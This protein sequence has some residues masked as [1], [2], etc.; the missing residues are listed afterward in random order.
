MAFKLHLLSYEAVCM[1]KINLQ[2]LSLSGNLK[3]PSLK[4]EGDNIL[5]A[6]FSIPINEKN[7]TEI[8]EFI[9]PTKLFD[10]F[11]NNNFD[12]FKNN[13][14]ENPSK[15]LNKQNPEFLN[16]ENEFI[17]KNGINSNNFSEG[18]TKGNLN[19][20]FKENKSF[21]TIFFKSKK[22]NNVT[23]KIDISDYLKSKKNFGEKVLKNNQ[24][25][26]EDLNKVKIQFN[27][28][29]TYP[30]KNILKNQKITVSNSK[31]IL[32]DVKKIDINLD[33]NSDSVPLIEEKKG[34]VEMKPLRFNNNNELSNLKLNNENMSFTSNSVNKAGNLNFDKN[35]SNGQNNFTNDRNMN[36]VLDNFIEQLDLSEKGWT[37]KLV[38][39][40]EKA[41]LDGTEEIELF[42]KP[43]E[44]G[45]LKINLSV[46]KNNAKI[47]FKAENIFTI[48]SLQ[49]NEVLLT[50]FFNEQGINIEKTNYENSNFL[51]NNSENF[52][53]NAKKHQ[54]QNKNQNKSQ[55]N[56]DDKA[57]KIDD[58]IKSNNSN[59]I[60]NIKA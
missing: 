24:P 28:L 46:N 38:L 23:L 11:E 56:P 1:N 39:R 18:N 59:Y 16:L 42:L 43:K 50:K 54:N 26:Q 25:K 3:D 55:I 51:M 32:K 40:V 10:S 15:L 31:Y 49:Q 41:L 52:H 29:K 33:H 27:N 8:S 22:Q 12:S 34:F 4:E 53:S 30:V 14:I 36:F 44:L 2:G 58:N 13:N 20:L 45:S 48:Q 9:I 6:L 19:I 7:N 47:N 5:G 35:L 37:E 57:G 60:I 17:E 21:K